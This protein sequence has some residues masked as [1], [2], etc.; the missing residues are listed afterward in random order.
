MTIPGDRK[1]RRRSILSA[2][3][4]VG[5]HPDDQ[6]WSRP[7]DLAGVGFLAGVSKDGDQLTVEVR[8]RDLIFYLESTILASVGDLYNVKDIPLESRVSFSGNIRSLTPKGVRM[9]RL[10]IR[11]C[12]VPIEKAVLTP[13][14]DLAA[15]KIL[16]GEVCIPDPDPDQPSFIMLLVGDQVR[17]GYQEV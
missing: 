9:G 13:D 8:C 11:P 4:I 2:Y 17:L 10:H 6:Y 15:R 5:S 16:F 1:D 7:A 14:R 3:G 12:E